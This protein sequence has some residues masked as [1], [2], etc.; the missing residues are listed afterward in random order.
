VFTTLDYGLQKQASEIAEAAA[1]EVK[2][3][4]ERVCRSSPRPAVRCDALAPQVALVAMDPQT[5]HVLSMVG[6]AQTSFNYATAKRSPGSAI[7]P[8]FYLRAIEHG[9]YHGESFTAATIIDPSTDQLTSYRPSENIGIRSSVRIGVAKSYNFHAVAAAESA[10]LMPTVQFVGQLTGS[11]PEVTGMAA[12]GGA[13]GS[14]T[15]LLNLTQAYSVFINNGRF[16]PATFHESFVQADARRILT[17]APSKQVADPAAAFIVTQMLRSVVSPQGT[18]PNFPSLAGFS[19]NSSIA[20]KSGTGM[21]ADVWF[22]AFTPHLVVGVWVGL[23]Q[24]EMP[25]KMED[26][27]TGARIAAPIAAK[28]MR[29]VR[30]LHPELLDGNFQQPSNVVRLPVDPTRGC[31]KD[32]SSSMEYFVVGREPAHCSNR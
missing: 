28:F 8:L 1:L 13:G 15:S 29:S 32:N 27:F 5:G 11:H 30:Q 9:S 25:L 24:N 19:A 22:V 31:V 12:I 14:E 16:V 6:G 2:T 21:I 23:P 20:G 7:K 10:D 18:T 4:I 3:K 17:S 26:G